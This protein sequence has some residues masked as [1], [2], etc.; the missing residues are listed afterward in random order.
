MIDRVEHVALRPKISLTETIAAKL[1]TCDHPA[2]QVYEKTTA[3]GGVQYLV[4]C[5]HCGSRTEGPLPHANVARTMDVTRIPDKSE[6]DHIAARYQEQR[7]YKQQQLRA[8]YEAYLESPEWKA[9][10]ELVLD[11][12]G[13]CVCCGAAIEHVHHVSYERLYCEDLADLAGVCAPCHQEIHK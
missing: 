3:N 5:T 10:R 11:R 4:C 13:F 7:R 6:A 12:D 1:A 2:T 9:L 8:V